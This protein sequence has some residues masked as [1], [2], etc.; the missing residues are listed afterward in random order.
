[1]EVI[2]IL[3]ISIVLFIILYKKEVIKNLSYRSKKYLELNKEIEGLEQWKSRLN[4]DINNAQALIKHLINENEQIAKEQLDKEITAIRVLKMKQL[5]EEQKEKIQ[6]LLN[7][8]ENIKLQIEP[9]RQELLE[10][11]SKQNAIIAAKKREREIENNKQFHSIQLSQEAIED[12]SFLRQILQQIHKK[13]IISKIIWENYYMVPTKDMLKRV[14]GNDKKCGVYKITDI[15][16]NECYIGQS[17]DIAARLQQHIK[18]TLGIQSIADQYVHHIMA[19]RGI[20][21]FLFEIIT[22]CERN[23]LNTMEKYYI[24][25]YK[26]NEYGWNMTKGGS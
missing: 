11:E 16:T 19:E 13:E 9:L 22:L 12:I 3:I 14:I 10:Y 8:E 1:M 24:N 18:G 26:S 4:E 21:N 25:F 23:Q 2:I 5:D 6:Q 17:V 7:E 20:E 15:N